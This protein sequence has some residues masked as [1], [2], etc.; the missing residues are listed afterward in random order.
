MLESKVARVV[1]IHIYTAN[2]I[3]NFINAPNTYNIMVRKWFLSFYRY[4]GYDTEIFIF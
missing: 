4:R 2:Q 3:G 1:L